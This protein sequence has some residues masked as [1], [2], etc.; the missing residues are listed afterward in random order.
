MPSTRWHWSQRYWKWLLRHMVPLLGNAGLHWL[1][2]RGSER[3]CHVDIPRALLSMRPAGRE[4]RGWPQ[5]TAICGRD[6]R[7]LGIRM[8][9]CWRI[10][11]VSLLRRH[12]RNWNALRVVPVVVCLWI[13][14]IWNERRPLIARS[15]HGAWKSTHSK[16]VV[17]VLWWDRERR[18]HHFLHW[19][20]N[21]MD[22]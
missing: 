3:I 21:I 4:W 8:W 14:E 19:A 22:R 2:T 17:W 18:I 1:R 6:G 11:I 20:R 7:C 12:L 15:Y 9:I 10:V 5:W 13:P 16:C